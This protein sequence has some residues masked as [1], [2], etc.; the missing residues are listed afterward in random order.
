MHISQ[1]LDKKLMA[2]SDSASGSK[3]CYRIAR[4]IMDDS[5]SR[6]KFLIDTGADVSV[7]PACYTPNIGTTKLTKLFAA[8]GSPIQTYGEKRIRLSF[9]L[10][11]NFT[12]TFLLAN[13]NCA[14]IG[15]DFLRHYDLLVDM[16]EG[17]L[18][19]RTTL[20]ES[21]GSP[22]RCD[23]ARILAYNKHDRYSQL[24]QEFKD[25]ATI[26]ANRHPTD[27]SVTHHITTK[28]PP[29]YARARRLAGDKL[30]A[31]KK[32]FEYLMEKGICRPSKSNWASPLHLVRKSNGEWRPCGDYRSLN[33]ITVPDRYTIPY[34]H[35]VTSILYGKKIF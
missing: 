26:N 22:T 2:S 28:G 20:L 30:L 25:L 35:D 34:L 15:S 14:I 18:I 8:N 29:T 21:K 17:K 16:K 31:A 13:V 1:Q 27:T 3:D 4:L 23:V 5:N 9:G 33:D 10:R 7:L 12:W 6:I 24:L 19:D 11:R 32:E